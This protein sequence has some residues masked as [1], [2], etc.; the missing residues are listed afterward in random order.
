MQPL[1]GSVHGESNSRSWD[2]IPYGD[3]KTPALHFI[4]LIGKNLEF[5]NE[6]VTSIFQPLS[7]NLANL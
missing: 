7:F 6:A 3:F 1:N 5:R 4:Q 2:H